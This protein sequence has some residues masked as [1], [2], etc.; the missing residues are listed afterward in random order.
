MRRL[1]SLN[2]EEKIRPRATFPTIPL[3]FDLAFRSNRPDMSSKVHLNSAMQIL[4]GAETNGWS[5]SETEREEL[6]RRVGEGLRIFFSRDITCR[7]TSISTKN[8]RLDAKGRWRATD[9][10]YLL[11]AAADEIAR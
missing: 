9:I 5:S 3:N 7:S 10:P 11:Q 6:M 2:L 1:P 4:N 8:R